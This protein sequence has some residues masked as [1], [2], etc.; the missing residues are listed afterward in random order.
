MVS[1]QG[2]A[3]TPTAFIKKW[4]D[5][6]LTERQAA[7]E[8]FLDLC[9]LFDH[10][11]PTAEDPA[12]EFYAFEK[13]APKVGGGLGFADVW[14]KNFF[15]WEYKRKGS[16][17]D[18]ALLQLV[19]YAPALQNPPL[20]VVSDIE[21]IRIHTAWTNT[22]PQTFDIRLEELAEPAKR[23]ILRN[24]FHDPERLKPA[25][26]RTAVT[27]GAA[28]KFSEIADRLRG[29]GTAEEVAHFVNQLVFCFFAQSVRLLP[30]GL[31][32][33]VLRRSGN[34]GG[35]NKYLDRLAPPW[36]LV[37]SRS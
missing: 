18:D 2:A 26:T 15:A 24:V 4:K 7:Q 27:Q 5:V 1:S 32:N 21:R 30:E 36:R 16:N 25:L 31:L 34:A 37:A 8:H 19:R 28:E 33:R 11:S 35:A 14:K 13:N 20:H 23:E 10:P 9:A 12:G 29:R 22:V 17:L 3:V 6:A